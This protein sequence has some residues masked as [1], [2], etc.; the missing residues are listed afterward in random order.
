[1]LGKGG[2]LAAGLAALAEP[3]LWL[4]AFIELGL[5]SG[6]R[7]QNRFGPDPYPA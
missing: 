7:G 1:M 5:L 6:T 2:N 4:W 3:A